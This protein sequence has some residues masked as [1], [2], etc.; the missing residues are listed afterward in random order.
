MIRTTLRVALATALAAAL[1]H[2][3]VAEEAAVTRRAVELRQAPADQGAVVAA[4]PAQAPVTRLQ[5]RRGPW[6]QV[7]TAEGATG[8]VHLFDIGP[9]AAPGEGSGAGGALRGLSG[10]FGGS[11]P[12]QAGSTAGIRGLDAQDIANATPNPAAVRQMEGL[13]Q[14]EGEA[15]AFAD[16]AALRPVDVEP[17]PAPAR[18]AAPGGT[19]SG[20]PGSAP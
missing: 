18:G 16:R 19:A 5:E 12:T 8:W 9:A 20:N 2:P 6:V 3:A 10:L 15:R 1:A 14:G 4:L 7:R 17:L 11:R 13:R